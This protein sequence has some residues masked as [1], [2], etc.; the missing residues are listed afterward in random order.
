MNIIKIYTDGACSGNPGPGGWGVVFVAGE[1][2]KELY[3]GEIH[4]TNNAMELKACIE[5]LKAL[6]ST[7]YLVVLVT[8]SKYV[9]NGITKW[10]VGWK[11]RNWKTTKKQPVKNKKLWQELDTLNDKYHVTW[12]WVRGHN[13]DFGN[14]RADELAKMGIDLAI[15]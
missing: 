3:G 6:K 12:R 14:E 10:I 7:A 1:R 9:T 8:D 13:G 4:T 5:A 2:R 11:R 15:F